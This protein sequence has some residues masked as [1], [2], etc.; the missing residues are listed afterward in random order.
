MCCK[1]GFWDWTK[2]LLK[3]FRENIGVY[4]CA[5]YFDEEFRAHRKLLKELMRLTPVAA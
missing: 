3:P 5:Y 1:A 2:G 4:D